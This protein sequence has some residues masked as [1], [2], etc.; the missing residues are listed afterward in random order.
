MTN[1]RVVAG[2][3]VLAVLALAAGA[4]AQPAAAPQGGAQDPVAALQ[5][6]LK[7]GQTLIRQYEWVETTIVSMK[8]E[9]KARSQNRC[10]YG[11]DGKVQKTPIG[12]APQ[13][14]EDSGGGRRGARMKERIV[15][16]KKDEIQDY[17]GRAANLIH[18]YVPPSPAQIQSAKDAGRLVVRPQ[19]GGRA[20]LEIAQYLQPGDALTIDLDTGAA[21]LLGLGVKT[22]LGTPE[23]PVT[24]AVQMAN[25][26]DGALYAA[27]TTLEAKAK[28]IRVVIQNSGHRPL[29]R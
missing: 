18:M 10:Y 25:L 2:T 29:P 8:G 13:A 3:C 17:M 21:R 22:Y 24:L 12:G 9:E 14:Q 28:E 19:A 23:D 27:Q 5:Q 11:V 26:P 16:K 20:S 7:Q 1:R 15:E 6:S 4:A